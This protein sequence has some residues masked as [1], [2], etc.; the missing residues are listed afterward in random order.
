MKKIGKVICRDLWTVLLDI[1]A[2][3]I[4]WFLALLV[5]FYVNGALLPSAQ[6]SYIPGFLRFAPF[7]TVAA[8]LVFMAFR[9]YAGMWQF[10]GMNDMWRIVAANGVTLLLQLLGTTLILPPPGQSRM[11]VTYY[12][13][14]IMLQFLM[15]V[16]I[17][18]GY[19]IILTEKQKIS[20]RGA[21]AVPTLIIGAGETARKAVIHLGDTPFKV[22][23]AADEKD[24]GKMINGVPVVADWRGKLDAVQAV[25]IADRGLEA[26]VRREIREECERRGI[27]VQD[28]TGVLANLIGRV[29]LTSLL[30]LV[31]GEVTL[32]TEGETRKFASGEEA[33]LAIRE[34]YE[35]EKISGATVTLKQSS[36]AVYEGYDDWAREHQ[37]KT[38][39]EVSFF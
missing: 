16:L 15:V 23:A 4:S 20:A 24:A 10:A 17:R 14:G 19:R 21:Q 33:L 27:K 34:H 28:Y 35:V 18:F 11:P 30:S 1:V 29:P 36:S 22:I 31:P 38:G 32:E 12:G 5:R 3:N 6:D 13:I 39:E 37:E 9:L 8:I 26:E 7:Y 2:L 25:F